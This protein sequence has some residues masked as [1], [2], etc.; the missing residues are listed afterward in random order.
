MSI[1]NERRDLGAVAI[2]IALCMLI[3]MGF[4]AIAVDGGM[5]IDERRQEQSGV[6]A[7]TLSAGISAQ[8]TP[9]QTGCATFS[10]LQL[11]TCNGAVVAMQIIGKNADAVYPITAFDGA[12][13]CANAS[14]PVEFRTGGGNSGIISTVRDGATNRTLECIRWNENLSRVHIKLP[15]TQVA[16]TFGRLLGRNSI[17]VNAFAEAEAELK[18]PGQLIPFVVGPT[19]GGAN[20]GCLFEPS[21]GIASPPCDGPTQGN[22]GYM[23]PSLYGD[24]NLNTP[25]ACNP[26]QDGISATLAK[27]A[28]HIYALNSSV[29]GVA[30][31]RANCPNKNQLIDQIDV[32]TGG[33]AVPIEVGALGMI[34]GTEGRLRCKDGDSAEP[35]WVNPPWSS[36]AC[37]NVNGNHP[38]TL[39]SVALW[40]F[41]NAGA[42][43]ESGGTCTTSIS[44]RAGMTTCLAAWRAYGTHSTTLFTAALATT[45]RFAWVPRVNA[46]PFTGGSGF[47][48]IEEFLPVFLQT[49]YLKCI[50][51]GC[52][53][54]FDPGQASSGACVGFGE[55]CGWPSTGN[56]NLDAMS[57]FILRADM[58]PFPLDMFPG[59]PGQLV[60]NLSR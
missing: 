31:D 48:T 17:D 29:P 45:P 49:M 4:A 43:A 1:T 21:T 8:A 30:N 52:D 56:K 3:F 60:Y 58:L 14:F 12:T 36:S 19:G 26:P 50:P 42:A 46:D 22:F 15:I 38:E 40:S 53:V 24:V 51:A 44:N 34:F 41:I 23:L 7:G 6:D 59:S 25:I 35:S 18:R 54:A 13:H 11:A 57:A 39:D 20:L 37:A 10:G 47:Y 28:D 55:S 16:T 27:G 2:L 5:A 33:T 9:V 32:R